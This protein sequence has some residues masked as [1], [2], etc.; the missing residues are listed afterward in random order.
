M[1]W[2]GFGSFTAADI[3]HQVYVQF[4][5]ISLLLTDGL[6]LK[7]TLRFYSGFTCIQDRLLAQLSG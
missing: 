1:I 7:S 4:S 3:H 5:E 6:W 2:Q